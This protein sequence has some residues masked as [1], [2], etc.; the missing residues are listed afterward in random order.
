MKM[1]T[2][3]E[4]TAR[5]W[6]NVQTLAFTDG[7][8]ELADAIDEAITSKRAGETVAIELDSKWDARVKEYHLDEEG[9][10]ATTNYP[11]NDPEWGDN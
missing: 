5:D 7:F 3:H 9:R 2:T 6:N 11:T 8:N 1:R 10:M 4:M